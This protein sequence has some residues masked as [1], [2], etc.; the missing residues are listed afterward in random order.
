MFGKNKK[1]VIDLSQS[2]VAALHY[3]FKVYAVLHGREGFGQPYANRREEAKKL[4]S[5]PPEFN[6][7]LHVP[8]ITRPDIV[9]VDGA[10]YTFKLEDATY[11]IRLKYDAG[12]YAVICEV[13][14]EN[15]RAS[16]RNGYSR[17]LGHRG[18]IIDYE[19]LNSGKKW[20]IEGTSYAHRIKA[21]AEEFRRA[22]VG[23]NVDA[24]KARLR[25]LHKI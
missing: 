18:V 11:S 20:R 6:E 3:L 14:G 21:V 5:L 16:A 15:F 17:I 4:V 19:E 1:G 2:Q 23:L 7:T 22:E 12:W 24:E 10:T 8:M 9:W 13:E 25:E